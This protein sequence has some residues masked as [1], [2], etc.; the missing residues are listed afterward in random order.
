MLTVWN[1]S[2]TPISL[3]GKS[4]RPGRFRQ[5]E[6][7]WVK[8]YPDVLNKEKERGSIYVGKALPKLLKRELES[9]MKLLKNNLPIDVTIKSDKISPTL[10][11]PGEEVKLS[12]EKFASLKS[13]LGGLE[14]VEVETNTDI[15]VVSQQESELPDE[16]V[17]V[18]HEEGE[19]VVAEESQVVSPPPEETSKKKK[20]KKSKKK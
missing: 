12:D 13:K 2:T 7:D 18:R 19:I 8:K 6:S 1:I 14:S 10:V 15:E 9:T 4:V 3:Y 20:P 5:I 17:E 16:T 11:R